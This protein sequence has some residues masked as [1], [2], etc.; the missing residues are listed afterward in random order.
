MTNI[1][2]SCLIIGNKGILLRGPSGSGKTML[3]LHLLQHASSNNQFAAMV[4]DD[5]VIISNQNNQLVAHCPSTIKGRIEV[6]GFGINEQPYIRSAIINLVVNIIQPEELDRCP[7]EITET[8]RAVCLPSVCV[9]KY[10]W[11]QAIQI[12]A[13][14]LM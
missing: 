10:H 11:E 7:E 12:I 4:A 1:H 14:K 13:A 9:P 8:L 3:M 2:A 5:Q 6:R